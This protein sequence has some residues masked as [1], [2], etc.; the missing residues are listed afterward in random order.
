MS[1]ETIAAEKAALRRIMRARR[2]ALAPEARA[3]SSLAVRDRLIA[4]LG[5]TRLAPGSVISGYWPIH[6]ELDPRPA[7]QALADRGYRLA[8]PVSIAQGER[9]AFRAWAP[10]EPLAPDMMRI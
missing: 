5:S 6:D 2:A 1:F 8:L 9:L 7:L 10:G 3:A 4:W